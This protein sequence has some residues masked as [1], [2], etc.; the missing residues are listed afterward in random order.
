MDRV[1]MIKELMSRE[2]WQEWKHHPSTQKYLR[3]LQ[4]NR[5]WFLNLLSLGGTLSEESVEKTAL[6]TS[7]LLGKL[8]GLGLALEAKFED[9]LISENDPQGSS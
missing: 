3:Y 4:C 1:P 9:E 8:S 7:V 6:M 2:E 5:E